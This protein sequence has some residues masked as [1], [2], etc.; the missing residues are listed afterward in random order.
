MGD[1]GRRREE[2]S[3]GSAASEGK[4]VVK[5]GNVWNAGLPV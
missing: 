4:D 3:L 5:V 1:I 2:L